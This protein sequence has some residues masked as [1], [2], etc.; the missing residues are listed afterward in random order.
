MDQL[1]NWLAHVDRSAYIPKFNQE[2]PRLPQ[3]TELYGGFLKWWYCT[4]KCLV[5]KGKSIYKLD[6][7][8]VP[9]F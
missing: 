4:P 9:L 8:G 6:D 7:L 5:S 1:M 3:S 2:T